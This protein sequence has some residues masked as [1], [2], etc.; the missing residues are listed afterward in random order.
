MRVFVIMQN[1]CGW[2]TVLNYGLGGSSQIMSPTVE[3]AKKYEKIFC[4]PYPWDDNHN[5]TQKE[6]LERARKFCEETG[7]RIKFH[8][9]IGGNCILEDINGNKSKTIFFKLASEAQSKAVFNIYRSYG[10]SDYYW[11]SRGGRIEKDYVISAKLAQDI[12][13]TYWN[14]WKGS[15]EQREALFNKRKPY[16]PPRPR[17]RRGYGYGFDWDDM[18]DCP[19]ALNM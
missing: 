12:I 14:K 1:C 8:Q 4:V 3:C 16:N 7:K 18:I 10:F 5:I 2:D 17:L 11:S 15:V 9:F 19:D 6:A 13:Y